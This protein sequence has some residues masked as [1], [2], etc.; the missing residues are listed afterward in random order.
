MAL[1]DL[2]RAESITSEFVEGAKAVRWVHR[3][4]VL[5]LGK[6]Q[7][8][9]VLC[10]VN[11]AGDRNVLG[12]VAGSSEVF[13]GRK[14]ASAANDSELVFLGIYDKVVQQA[15]QTNALD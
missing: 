12:D 8:S 15:V 3:C 14:A 9:G 1:C 7:L 10:C 5:V 2:G 11:R 6:A 13:Q 4:V